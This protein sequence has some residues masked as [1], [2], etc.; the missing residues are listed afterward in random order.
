MF[1][2]FFFFTVVGFMELPSLIFVN[3]VM[4][5]KNRAKQIK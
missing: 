5:N 4:N 1:L 3:I 2:S